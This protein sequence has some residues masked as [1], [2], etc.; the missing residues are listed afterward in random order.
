MTSNHSEN[1]WNGYVNET[2]YGGGVAT[3]YDQVTIGSNKTLSTAT[4]LS[5]T[6]QYYFKLN[7][8]GGGEVEKDITTES[9]V[10]FEAVIALMNAEINEAIFSLYRGNLVCSTKTS[11]AL[12]A[13]TTGTDLFASL[14]DYSALVGEASGLVYVGLEPADT[15]ALTSQSMPFNET[16]IFPV[17]EYAQTAFEAA[18]QGKSTKQTFTVDTRILDGEKHQFVQNSIWMMRAT[19]DDITAGAIPS[20]SWCEVYYD[21]QRYRGAYGCY[22]TSYT[23]SIPT[24]SADNAPKE[25]IIYKSYNVKTVTDGNFSSAKAWLGT[26]PKEHFDFGITIGDDTLLDWTNAVLTVEKEY[27]EKAAGEELHKYPYLMKHNWT[28]EVTTYDYPAV[29]DDLETSGASLVSVVITGWDSKTLTLTNMK[30]Q[31]ESVNIREV[32]EKGMKE[33]SFMMEIGGASTAVVT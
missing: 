15:A 5:T 30:V 26:A 25:D 9:D 10:T 17:K 20:G 27:T 32:P 19:T 23:L 21:G 1:Y 16:Q 24:P 4:G 29:I 18:G 22:G 31:P 12:A 7:I 8:D 3:K 11:I 14:T 13:G 33:Y 6:T 28:L 2:N